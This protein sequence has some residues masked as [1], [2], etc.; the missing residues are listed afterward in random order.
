VS[1]NIDCDYRVLVIDDEFPARRRL[2]ALL[3][4]LAGYRWVGEAGNAV[5]GLAQ[6]MALQV[7]IVLLDIS[8]PGTDG[9]QLAAELAALSRPPAVIFCTAHDQH[10][11][12]AFQVRA[13][14]YLL[15]PVKSEHL[16]EAL[17][18][19]SRVNRAQIPMAGAGE[20][21]PASALYLLS[22]SVRAE[23]RIEVKQVAAFIASHKYVSAYLGEREIILDQSLKALEQVYAAEFIRIHRNALVSRR[24]L[25][26]IAHS[27]DDNR[28]CAL[29]RDCAIAP[30][31]SRRHLPALRRLLR[32][33]Q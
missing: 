26:G 20:Q 28:P 25:R 8:M 33:L 1:A 12:A 6:V 9:L 17:Q 5:Q 22:K 13:D 27:E 15:K 31:I 3:G 16:L 7:D 30:L 32:Q 10:A 19:A 11:L 2:K 14:G 18:R 4:G 29:L 23:E 21:E 24:H